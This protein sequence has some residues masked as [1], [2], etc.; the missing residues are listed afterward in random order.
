MSKP[1]EK[2]ENKSIIEEN[3]ER[4]LEVAQY[5]GKNNIYLR[6]TLKDVMLTA[7]KKNDDGQYIAIKCR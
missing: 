5:V 6:K 7:W 2:N 4:A 3:K 1:E